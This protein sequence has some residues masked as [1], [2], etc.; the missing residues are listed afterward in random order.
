MLAGFLPDLIRSTLI[1]REVMGGSRMIHSSHVLHGSCSKKKGGQRRKIR[2]PWES[3]SI[4]RR[5][6][7][8]CINVFQGTR[9]KNSVHCP[10]SEARIMKSRLM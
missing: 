10:L 2:A 5:F 4:R 6:V 9:W 8:G 1:A 3:R 7:G